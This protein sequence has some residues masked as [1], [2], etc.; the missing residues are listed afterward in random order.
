M[1]V[2][3]AAPASHAPAAA[4]RVGQ[5]PAV[6]ALPALRASAKKSKMRALSACYISVTG[7]FGLKSTALYRQKKAA[8]AV[9]AAGVKANLDR[10]LA[11]LAV[12]TRTMSRHLFE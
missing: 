10:V 11:Y 5:Q 6:G 9:Q 2:P 3:A 4:L 12:T 1:T 8:C 7:H